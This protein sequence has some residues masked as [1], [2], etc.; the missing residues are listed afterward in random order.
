[1]RLKDILTKYLSH[2]EEK[3]AILELKEFIAPNE[4]LGK[5]N[6]RVQNDYKAKVTKIL[7]MK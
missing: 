2:G 7:D 6:N 1:M 5:Y 3:N 4:Y